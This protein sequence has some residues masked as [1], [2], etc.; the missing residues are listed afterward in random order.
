MAC[1]FRWIAAEE[2][3]IVALHEKLS[4]NFESAT[5]K[6]KQLKEEVATLQTELAELSRPE[7]LT[8]QKPPTL[9]DRWVTVK[10]IQRLAL[11]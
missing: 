3:E 6:P 10:P 7:V 1:N 2:A 8:W 11:A 4:T 5:A 9:L